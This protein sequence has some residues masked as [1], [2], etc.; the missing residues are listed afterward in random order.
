[1]RTVLHDPKIVFVVGSNDAHAA[2]YFAFGG[3]LKDGAW[4]PSFAGEYG[5]GTLSGI[6]HLT[7]PAITTNPN[8][9]AMK[10]YIANVIASSPTAGVGPNGSTIYVLF[11]PAGISAVDDSSGQ[12]NTNCSLYSGYHG[13]YGTKGDAWAVVQDCPNSDPVADLQWSTITAS[14]EIAEAA[15]NPD[16]A[17]GYHLARTASSPWVDSPSAWANGGE[18]GDACEYSNFTE[19]SFTYQRVW[20]NAAAAK[21]LDPCVPSLPQVAY[22]NTSAQEAWYTIQPGASVHV[23]LT[24]WSDR[25]TVDWGVWSRIGHASITG[26]T[27]SIVN[28]TDAGK[29]T[30]NNNRGS[31]LLVEA[32]ANAPHG[33]WAVATILSDPTEG[34]DQH[35]RWYVGVHVP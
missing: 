12:P 24:G 27:A 25:E 11:L 7:G 14:H 3:A 33:S 5:L 10:S 32:P 28:P 34:P 20:S 16:L 13:R 19:G 4:W 8:A 26:F 29:T 23:P 17:N 31:E 35:H 21:G 22:A 18:L 2:D 1:M 30:T 15:T 6:V 9:T